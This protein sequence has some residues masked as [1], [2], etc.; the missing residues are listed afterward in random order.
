MSDQVPVLRFAPSPTGYLHIGGA[1]TALFNYLLARKLGGR[2]LL[3]IED[4]DPRRSTQAAL[5]VILEGLRWLGIEWDGEIVFQSLGRERHLDSARKLL[6]KGTAYRCFCTPD[7]LDKQRELARLK[8][9]Q[10]IYNRTCLSLDPQEAAKRAESG[11]PHVVRFR[12]P[13]GETIYRDGIHDKVRFDNRLLE[14]FVILRSDGTPTYQ[15]AVVADDIHMG[16]THI[17]RGDDHIS[18]TPKQ[19]LLYR[20]LEVDMPEFAHVPLI[21]GPDKKR[22]SKR[23][24]A[25]SLI[26]YREMGFLASAVFNYLAL[27]GWSPD[28]DREI[29]EREELVN[30][31]SLKGINKRNAV[32]DQTKLEWMNG[33]YFSRMKAEEIFKLVEPD[34]TAA[35]LIGKNLSSR[36]K[37]Y[38]MRVLDLVKQR[39]RLKG[40]LLPRSR[41]F[42]P[43][44]L[45]YDK[46]A[47]AKHWKPGTAELLSALKDEL[48]QAAEW[49]ETS[50]ENL[51]RT[52]AEKL[53]VSPGKLIHPLRVALTGMAVSPGIFEV[54]A[55][56][57]RKL[58]LA[59]LDAAL[60]RFKD[61]V[62]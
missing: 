56:M 1:R 2:F 59:R 34:F 30:L 58:V 8:K 27:L 14:D 46:A 9:E 51:L 28:D 32:F 31:F 17:I 60:V 44:E 7:Q 26:E 40:E 52:L 6:E 38:L 39:C 23:H 24:G 48:R 21:L 42:F 18:N 12:I 45:E 25:V 47:V 20:A 50:L 15:L 35:G 10:L 29:L 53:Q 13:P 57:G 36:R 43:V 41:Y 33:R 4:T 62:G 37:D 19:I 22:L 3:R 16:I 5:E 54:M 61:G 11:E 55:L 49:S